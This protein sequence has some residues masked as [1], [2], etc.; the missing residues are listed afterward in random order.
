MISSIQTILGGEGPRT[1]CRGRRAVGGAVW[2]E[3]P[4]VV[5]AGQGSR[6]RGHPESERRKESSRAGIE[7]AQTS[8]NLNEMRAV[9]AVS[10]VIDS[11]NVRNYGEPQPQPSTFLTPAEDISYPISL[12]TE[13]DH[14][15]MRVSQFK[16]E[17]YDGTTDLSEAQIPKSSL[18]GRD[19]KAN[20][21][22]FESMSS[23]N[24]GENVFGMPGVLSATVTI[25]RHRFRATYSARNYLDCLCNVQVFT[26]PPSLLFDVA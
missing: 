15:K 17:Y 2:S 14:P 11:A 21:D 12:D 19:G 16:S 22:A 25:F 13:F 6:G 20:I 4:A 8:E 18:S 10:Q 26:L 5:G 23:S 7:G 9:Q 1:V 3:E 24:S